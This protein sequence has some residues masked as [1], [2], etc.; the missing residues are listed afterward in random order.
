MLTLV[1]PEVAALFRL[2]EADFCPLQIVQ[3]ALP[4]LAWVST[5]TGPTLPTVLQMQIVGGSS[6]QASGVQTLAQYVP[7]L[8]RLL[9]FRLLEQL[10]QV[11]STVMISHF[12]GLI[13]GLNMSF[14]DVEKLAVRAVKMRLLAVRIDHR[15]GSMRLGS[16]AHETSTVR[17]KLATVASR[18]QRVVDGIAPPPE[19]GSNVPQDRREQVFHYARVHTEAH[20][21]EARRRAQLV[22]KRRSEAE[23]AAYKKNTEVRGARERVAARARAHTR[24]TQA[25]CSSVPERFPRRPASVRKDCL[26]T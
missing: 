9:V 2:F 1:R 11:Y 5:Q 25:S 8:Q 13:A 14:F 15:A 12:Q 19:E 26:A 22:Q 18:L 4:L 10:S 20:R 24:A 3:R 16:E 17:R 7:N 21:K 23:Q 6:A